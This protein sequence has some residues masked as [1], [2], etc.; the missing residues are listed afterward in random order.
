MRVGIGRAAQK[1]LRAERGR[2]DAPGFAAQEARRSKWQQA[3]QKGV[4]APATP[5]AAVARGITPTSGSSRPPGSD[6]E[7]DTTTHEL[8]DTT[9]QLERPAVALRPS[10]THVVQQARSMIITGDYRF[11]L[12]ELVLRGQRA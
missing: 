10:A 5:L 8:R 7:K 1:E 4:V 12:L 2:V 6:V 11:L 9:L 3:K